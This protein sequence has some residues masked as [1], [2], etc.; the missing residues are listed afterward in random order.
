MGADKGSRE[1]L[2]LGH[3]GTAERS[4][5]FETETETETESAGS[6]LTKPND[7]WSITLAH[8]PKLSCHECFL[9]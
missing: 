5:D 8:P 9:P 7:G 4:A 3:V 6:V 1:G 2:A